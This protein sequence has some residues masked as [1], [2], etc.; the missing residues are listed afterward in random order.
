MTSDGRRNFKN[1][2]QISIS[3]ARNFSENKLTKKNSEKTRFLFFYHKFLLCYF[4]KK[5]P[6]HHE[7]NIFEC[8][9]CLIIVYA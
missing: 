7:L 9:I 1:Y 8:V 4:T 5:I 2:Y 6:S 3:L